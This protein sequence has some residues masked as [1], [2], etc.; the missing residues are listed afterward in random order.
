M[1]IGTE[2]L[3]RGRRQALFA[4]SK[5]DRRQ[6]WFVPLTAGT[7]RLLI[8]EDEGLRRSKELE[9]VLDVPDFGHVLLTCWPAKRRGLTPAREVSHWEQRLIGKSA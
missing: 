1:L 6:P 9:L 8:T 7:H 4:R 2:L 5:L 3:S